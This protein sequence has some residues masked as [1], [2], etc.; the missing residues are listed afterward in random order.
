MKSRME[1]VFLDANILFS[2]AY[3]PD[4]RLKDLWSLQNIELVTSYLAAEEARR[5]L[6]VHKS[7]ALTRLDELIASVIIHDTSG[8]TATIPE[9]IE[10]V[11]KD[12][13]ILAGAIS[14]GCTHLITGDNQHFGHLFGSTIGGVKV[15]TPAQFLNERSE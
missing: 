2:A 7:E 5:N 1:R 10:P 12:V 6:R 3:R 13:H 8:S 9:G 4:S 15:M 11:E 14:A